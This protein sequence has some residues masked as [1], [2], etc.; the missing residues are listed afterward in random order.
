MKRTIVHID[1]EKCDGCGLC[2]PGCA[3]GALAV[4]DGKARLV[5]ESY[6]DGLG[7]CLGACPQGAL[8][9]TEREADPFDAEEVSHQSC[10][11][12]MVHAPSKAAAPERG[13]WPI[14]LHL[15]PVNAPFWQGSDLL[16][17]ADCVPST[18]SGFHDALLRGRRLIIACPKLDDTSGYLEKLTRI[19]AFNEINSLTVAVMEVPCCAGLERLART[20]LSSSGKSIPISI[21]TIG[22]D[23]RLK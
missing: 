1:E 4:I 14:Q 8:T 18:F 20:A 2:V 11:G 3:E 23:G 15:V 13:Q 16:L 12:S 19:L 22:V 17:A 7:A 21:I 5:K 10:P 6:C 9:V